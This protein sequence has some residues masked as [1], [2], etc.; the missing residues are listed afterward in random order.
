MHLDSCQLFAE[1]T[2]T[3]VPVHAHSRLRCCEADS[4]RWTEGC[5]G[6]GAAAVVG[7][8]HRQQRLMKSFSALSGVHKPSSPS[9]C[10]VFMFLFHSLSLCPSESFS[11][12]ERVAAANLIH[13]LG[14]FTLHFHKFYIFFPHTWD[15]AD[16]FT[17]VWK[18]KQVHQVIFHLHIRYKEQNM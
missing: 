4:S 3:T 16:V 5:K 1:H 8:P 2:Y 7:G 6:W 9:H 14:Q 18:A 15:R 17:A 13:S 12:L 10:H 11:V